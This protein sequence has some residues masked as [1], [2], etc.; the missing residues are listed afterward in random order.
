MSAMVL[1][2]GR[3]GS[4][5]YLG[6][7]SLAGMD[8]TTALSLGESLAVFGLGASE[9]VALFAGVGM[10]VIQF[11]GPPPRRRGSCSACLGSL[12]ERNPAGPARLVRPRSPGRIPSLGSSLSGRHARLPR[13]TS[14]IDLPSSSTPWGRGAPANSQ[15][16]GSR[17]EKSVSSP[18]RTPAGHHARPVHDEGL[19]GTVLGQLVPCRPAQGGRSSCHG[20]PRTFRCR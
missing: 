15:K 7:A 12:S 13:M 8:R 6:L 4:G 20:S 10:Q 3:G 18:V 9:Q 1:S 19:L 14:A 16:V 11:P 17:S 5:S 2:H